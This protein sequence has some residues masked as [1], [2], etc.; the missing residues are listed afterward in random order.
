ME[1]TSVARV[2]HP[3]PPTPFVIL[4]AHALRAVL[5][6]LAAQKLGVNGWSPVAGSVASVVT[7]PPPRSLACT[8]Y[9]ADHS[10]STQVAPIVEAVEGPLLNKMWQAAPGVTPA[11]PHS[12]SC[13]MFCAGCPSCPHGGNSGGPLIDGSVASV[14]RCGRAGHTSV[15]WCVTLGDGVGCGA[16]T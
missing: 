12:F 11:P 7:C 8:V 1:V 5:T 3:S 6:F 10:G 15:A 14:A 4:P 9:C 13:L 16:T 2:T